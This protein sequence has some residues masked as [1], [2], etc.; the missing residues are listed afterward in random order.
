M[1]ED[2][3]RH[4][5]PAEVVVRFR[6]VEGELATAPARR[7]ELAAELARRDGPPQ[8][9]PNSSTPPRQGFKRARPSGEGA[10]R[11]P[12]FGQLGRSRQRATPE[13]GVLCQPTPGAG[14]GA[15]LAAAPQQRVGTSPVVAVP[16]L[17][18]VVLEA[19]RYAATGPPGGRPTAAAYPG[20]FEPPRVFGPHL[21]AL[22]TSRPEQHPLSSAR[23]AR[24]GHDRWQ[25]GISQGARANALQRAAQR[26]RPQAA[27]SGGAGRASPV[28]GSAEP[29]ARVGGRT[30]WQWV[31]QPPTAS[32][33][34][35]RPRR[36]GAGGQECLGDA[37]PLAW[38]SDRGK[39]PR[40]APAPRHPSCLAHPLREL[41]Y[42]VDTEQSP[43]A[44][45][46]QAL[47]RGAIHRAPHRDAGALGGA[48]DP[49]AGA[50]IERRG[51][52]LLA[53]PGAGAA[54]SRLWVRLREHRAHLFRFLD[55]PA[56]PPT[57]HA[58]AQALR[59][60]V[61]PR[62]VPGGFRSQ[63]GAEA[64]ASAMTVLDTARTRGAD[65]L[66]PLHAAVGLPAAPPPG[67]PVP[68]PGR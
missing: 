63:W 42:G 30:H 31:C 17:A 16:P 15:D 6:H 20:G 58:S 51:A 22:W 59:H 25:R 61:G 38:G 49:A 19:G 57:N 43:W 3:L 44:Q 27:A 68:S 35:I 8:T 18:P 62:K 2:A 13:W 46:C 32:Y 12:P 66:T 53:T 33:H 10:T 7:A 11:G 54:A 60:A 14:C 65:L 47:R 41:P 37:E 48:A 28:L 67:L 39:P 29:S 4:R 36:T 21:A 24:L 40:G 45:A 52:A 50:A 26:R 9:P 34:V 23:R 1:A 64:P 5:S 55:D 56:V